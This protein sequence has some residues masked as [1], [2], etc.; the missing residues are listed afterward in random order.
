MLTRIFH[1]PG[2][3]KWFAISSHFRPIIK[4]ILYHSTSAVKIKSMH[5]IEKFKRKPR[6]LKLAIIFL[7]SSLIYLLFSILGP[8]T[9]STSEIFRI[10]V[11]GVIFI[12]VGAFYVNL[13]NIYELREYIERLNLITKPPRFWGGVM[14]YRRLR[15]KYKGRDLILTSEGD[16]EN[17]ILK[18]LFS[19]SLE[20][21]LSLYSESMVSPTTFIFDKPLLSNSKK[22]SLSGYNR[23]IVYKLREKSDF[24]EDT[25]RKILEFAEFLSAYSG[26]IYLNDIGLKLVLPTWTEVN[27][28][29]L[30]K[31]LE[32]IKDIEQIVADKG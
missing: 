11:A 12:L 22:Y 32:L 26:N 14:G 24:S 25:L 7:F 8:K 29:I 17:L 6:F 19:K 2:G 4:K 23:S 28:E 18:F 16:E 13:R 5:L 3:T 9:N 1:P 20:L 27:E 15:A 10:I 31:A 21:G 30:E